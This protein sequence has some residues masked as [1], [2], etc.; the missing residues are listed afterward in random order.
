MLFENALFQKIQRKIAWNTYEYC[1]KA[2]V[3]KRYKLVLLYA[4]NKPTY[5]IL[6]FF[7]NADC[8]FAGKLAVKSFMSWQLETSVS[9]L[10]VTDLASKNLAYKSLL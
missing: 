5:A 2:K 4:Y 6:T 9:L 1:M 3:G 8:Q 7:W 10:S